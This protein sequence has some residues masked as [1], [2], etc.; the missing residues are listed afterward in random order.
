MLQIAKEKRQ[1][2]WEQSERACANKLQFI[3]KEAQQKVDER[4][5]KLREIQEKIVTYNLAVMGIKNHLE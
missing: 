2:I 1:L 3:E 5:Q 4:N